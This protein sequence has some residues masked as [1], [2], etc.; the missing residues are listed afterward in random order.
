[1]SILAAIV[2]AAFA[3]AIL[4]ARVLPGGGDLTEELAVVG[5][6]WIGTV[7]LLVR[8]RRSPPWALL[9][10]RA[11]LAGR[12]WIFA[13]SLVVVALLA[14]TSVGSISA[15][16]LGLGVVAIVAILFAI[17]RREAPWPR[18]R[19]R[20]GIA[21]DATIV[22][23]LMLAIPDLVIFRP[24][25]A[26]TD[27]VT[28]FNNYLVQFHHN[29]FLGPANQVLHG[30]AVL[31]D[32]ASQY[33]IAPIYL[34]AGWFQFAPI[35]YGTFG[36]LDGA[37]FGLLFAAGYGLLRLAG[38]SRPLAAGGLAVAVV[39]LIYNLVYSVGTLPQHGPLRF[40]L[41]ML[42]ILA[43]TAEARWPTRRRAAQAAQLAVV[44]L[45]SIWALE[46]FAYTA[47]TFA[48][49]ACFQ[50]WIRPAGGRL[51][52][53]A[54]RATLAL[55]ACVVAQI[56]F[57]AATLTFAG[58]LPDWGL[59]LAYLNAFLF[60]KLGEL[61]YDFSPWS[62][63]LAAGAAY[64]ASAA[65]FVL[66]VP[67]R[68]DLVERE[69]TAL[70]ALCG[71]TA[72]GIALFTYFVDRSL[73]HVLPYV[74][75]PLLL[76]ATLWL[77]LLLRGALTGSQ[78]ARLGGFAFALSIA[79]LLVS[80]AWSSIGERFPR[81]ALAHAFPGGSSL[82]GA[83]HR[84]WHPPPLDPRSPEG[85]ALLDRYMPDQS[86]VLTLVAPDLETEILMRSGRAN[87]LPLSY[88]RE[89]SFVSSQYVGVLRRAVDDL[90]PGDRLLMQRDGLKVLDAPRARPSADPFAQPVVASD[91]LVPLQEWT[92][93]RIGQ[94]FELRVIHRDDQGFVVATLVRRR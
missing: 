54:S 33:G 80:V 43:A 11:H 21:F 60:G 14:F 26:T 73:D 39:V 36:F 90:E 77:S 93:Q 15:V 47:F 81:T 51:A 85:V 24:E 37:L 25:D 1:M 71:T 75:L 83:L 62:A 55:A 50:A 78:L 4:V 42:V 6:W 52:W 44:A 69:R 8:A 18:M 72:Y 70:T 23:L 20:W 86:R 66:L 88:A 63:G 32:T 22:G 49:I 16:P 84:L 3:L 48:A 82:R 79:V 59:Y 41:P 45:A 29:F 2:V 67:R 87:E 13:G 92:L 89:D 31:I 12:A 34:L 94:R 64:A 57:A 30:G 40:G 53:L 28:A 46:A 56:I 10:E 68:A 27:P 91:S 19:R 38:V 35:G 17:A 74:S 61:T 76:A 65:A 58:E 5:T 9:L 7:A